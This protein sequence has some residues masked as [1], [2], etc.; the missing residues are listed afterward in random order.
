MEVNLKNEET[1]KKERARTIYCS[2]EEWEFLLKVAYSEN[3]KSRNLAF[4][5]LLKKKKEEMEG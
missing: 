1:Q 3:H 5:N 4:R 2:D